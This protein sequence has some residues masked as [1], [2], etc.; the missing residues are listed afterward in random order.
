MAQEATTFGCFLEWDGCM[1]RT[2]GDTQNASPGIG[3][4]SAVYD[5]PQSEHTPGSGII[6]SSPQM[7]SDKT[8]GDTSSHTSLGTAKDGHKECSG[9]NGDVGLGQTSENKLI[10]VYPLH[11][12]HDE[13]SEGDPPNQ[14]EREPA[15]SSKPDSVDVID[16]YAMVQPRTL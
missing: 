3:S 14:S 12:F 9:K 4:E 6:A 2:P 16:R 7:D 10:Y 5:V 13:L 8:V 11:R 1:G 15:T